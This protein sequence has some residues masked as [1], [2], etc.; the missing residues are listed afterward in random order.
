MSVDN[1]AVCYKGIADENILSSILFSFKIYIAIVLSEDQDCMSLK[2][3]GQLR[4]IAKRRFQY[5]Y[6]SFSFNNHE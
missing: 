4:H 1:K 3:S 2:G 6:T 5:T